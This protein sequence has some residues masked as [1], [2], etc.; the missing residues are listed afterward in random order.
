MEDVPSVLKATLRSAMLSATTFANPAVV[1]GCGRPVAG[2][3][4]GGFGEYGGGHAKTVA[5]QSPMFRQSPQP[6]MSS[7]LH[8]AMERLKAEHQAEMKMM[9]M[10]MRQVMNDMEVAHQ[11][12]VRTIVEKAA[13]AER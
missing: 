1:G 9:K 12:E 3:C 10:E 4:G 13:D 6:S 7:N 11:K 5:A 8:D 2:G